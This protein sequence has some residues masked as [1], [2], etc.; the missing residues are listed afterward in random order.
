MK[1]SEHK[2]KKENKSQTWPGNV[3]SALARGECKTL[4][5]WITRAGSWFHAPEINKPSSIHHTA[6][7]VFSALFFRVPDHPQLA[8]WAERARDSLDSLPYS[9]RLTLARR[10]LR[11]DI[12]F[13]RPM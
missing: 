12:F 4:D 6:A 8:A 9:S 3:E 13:G 1:P 10:L 2:A 5:N 11:Y 7:S